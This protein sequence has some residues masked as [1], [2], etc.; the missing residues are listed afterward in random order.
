MDS[1]VDQPSLRERK[2]AVLH[3]TI[4]RRAID[5]ALLHGYE[6]L[7]VDM[8]CEASMVSPRTFFNYF[9]SKEG[10]ILGPPPP[11]PS[12]SSV[13]AFVHQR[14]GDVLSDFVLMLTDS[15]ANQ[16]PDRE[17][18][19]AR[20]LLIQRNPQLAA[21][22]MASIRGLEDQYVA[23]ILERFR[24]QELE[25]SSDFTLEDE[26]RMVIALTQGVIT[27]AGRKW[28]SPDFSGT[29][30]EVLDGSLR[31]VQAVVRGSTAL[32]PRNPN[33]PL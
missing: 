25:P 5:L 9:G 1:S 13:D 18:Y 7:T 2:R 24:A 32:V 19:L 4:E 20:Q 26:A 3:S 30:R 29:V 23:I 16:E 10:V 14:S 31:L 28:S 22:R 15:L 8:I 6:N 17:L 27:Y 33:A 12:P 11:M 21:K